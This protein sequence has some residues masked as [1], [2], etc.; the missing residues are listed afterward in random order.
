LRISVRRLGLK[1]LKIDLRI[2]RISASPENM[3]KITSLFRFDNF[4]YFP[5]IMNDDLGKYCKVLLNSKEERLQISALDFFYARFLE[6][7]VIYPL[8]IKNKITEVLAVLIN[9][10]ENQVEIIIGF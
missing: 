5:T 1:L 8:L 4:H 3:H 6:G 9:S 2:S 10:T 7:K